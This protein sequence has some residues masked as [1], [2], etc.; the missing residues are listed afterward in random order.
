MIQKKSIAYMVP[1]AVCS[2]AAVTHAATIQLALGDRVGSPYTTGT[3]GVVDAGDTWNSTGAGD[4]ST[5][6]VAQYGAIVDSAGNATSVV[7]KLGVDAGGSGNADYSTSPRQSGS[8][9]GNNVF[10]NDL[11]ENWLF[12]TGGNNIFVRVEGLDPGEYDVYALAREHTESGRTYNGYAGID[13]GGDSDDD[14]SDLNLIGTGIP[15]P[16]QTALDELEDYF[17]TSVTIAAGD[18]LIVAIDPTNADFAT[19]SGLQI[20]EVP[21]PASLTLLGLGACSLVRRRRK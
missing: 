20:V 8:T 2:S 5:G 3:D 14:I 15:A 19:L 1:V 17:T 10:D 18:A 9:S 4:G 21:E 16:D 11:W 12:S 7:V 13:A 6:N